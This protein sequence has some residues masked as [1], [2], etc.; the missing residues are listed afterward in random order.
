METIYR[1]VA[2]SERLPNDDLFTVLTD[3][4]KLFVFDVK[5]TADWWLEEI[6]ETQ[7]QKDKEELVEFLEALDRIGGLGFERHS[8]IKSLIQKHKA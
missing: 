3:K 7:L 8:Q 2:V 6:E 4:G 1:K 5:N